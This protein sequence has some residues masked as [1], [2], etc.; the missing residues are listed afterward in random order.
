MFCNNLLLFLQIRN[1]LYFH[2]RFCFLHDGRER[3]GR[4]PGH[5]RVPGGDQA[6]QGAAQEAQGRVQ[7]LLDI[8]II[9]C[10]TIVT[11]NAMP[12]ESPTIHFGGFDVIC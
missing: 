12:M 9:Y 4:H 1:Q 5:E 7:T 3:A 10:V 2:S 11:C 6:T 8:Y